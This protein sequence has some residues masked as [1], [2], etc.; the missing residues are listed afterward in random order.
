MKF[1]TRSTRSR[2]ASRCR[3]TSASA[4][5][6]ST[7]PTSAS[8]NRSDS[9]EPRTVAFSSWTRRIREVVWPAL[10][11]GLAT[12]DALARAVARVERHVELAALRWGDDAPSR[13]RRRVEADA[14]VG[15]EKT[16]ESIGADRA[17]VIAGLAT[18]RAALV[19]S[20][21][22]LKTL[23]I[24]FGH[25]RIPIGD[26]VAPAHAS[27]FRTTAR[28]TRGT[29]TRGDDHATVLLAIEL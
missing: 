13:L 5:S 6:S 18:E 8:T 25:A 19:A 21:L 28:G 27:S 7:H 26:P 24:H 23:P 29:G 15:E 17:G 9:R 2:W 12:V 4:T 16:A 20:A 1:S 22:T 14:F 3:T 11:N 10:V